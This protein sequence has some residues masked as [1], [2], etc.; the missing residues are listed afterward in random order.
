[1]SRV[2]WLPPLDFGHNAR[3]AVLYLSHRVTRVSDLYVR[4]SDSPFIVRR[5]HSEI[6]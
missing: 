3:T 6:G 2:L 5:S 4:G 1:M